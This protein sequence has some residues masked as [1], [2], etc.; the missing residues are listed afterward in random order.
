MNKAVFV[1]FLLFWGTIPEI[2]SKH[3]VGGEIFYTCQGIDVN[4][5][6][7]RLNFVMNIYRDCASTGADFDRPAKL[8]IYIK[9][10]SGSYRLYSVNDWNLANTSIVQ[11]NNPCVVQPP[12]ICVQKG[13]YV[14]SINLPIISES[15]FISYQ[16]CC[17]NESIS[18][19]ITP[20]DFGAAYT[21]EITPEAQRTC[22]NSPV[23][24]NFPPIIICNNQPIDFDH[25]VVDNEGDVVTYEFCTPYH[26][27]GKAGSV[28]NLGQ[29]TD[30]DGVTPDA[31][32]CIP[33]FGFIVFKAPLYSTSR[34]MGG[35]PI[36]SINSNTGFISGV[37]TFEGQYVV[38]VCIK[39]YRNGILLS[40]VQRD[41]QFNVINC[42]KNI[43]ASISSD[44]VLAG[45]K[46]IVNACG[47]N[48]VNLLN[49]STS[50]PIE[51]IRRYDWEFDINGQIQTF[52][53]KDISLTLPGNGSYK[54]FLYLNRG[55]GECSDTAEILINV[56]PGI[57]ADYV[58]NYDTCIAGPIQFTDLSTALNSNLV[59]WKYELEPG[60]SLLQRNPLYEYKT[61]GIKDI[62][63][64]IIDDNGC[65]DS[66]NKKINYYP[67]PALIVLNPNTFKGCQ[68]LDVYFENLS[69]PIDN[70]YDIEWDFGNG[71]KS[72]EISPKLTFTDEGIFTVNLKITSPIGCKTSAN[73][74]NWID[75]QKSPV[76]GFDFTPRKLNNFNNTID[77]TDLSVGSENHK[78]IFGDINSTPDRNLSYTFPDT[79][80][81][82]ISQI[83][84]RLNGCSDT[85]VQYIDVEPI[86]T[87]FMPNAFTPNGNGSNEVF[88][89]AGRFWEWME[90][91]NFTIWDRWGSKIY[92]SEDPNK[93]WNG[94]YDNSGL[95][96]QPGVYAYTIEY[97]AP[98]NKEVK[99]KGH[100]N[101]IR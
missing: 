51:N 71:I 5:N 20:G 87:Y 42:T 11:S 95:E 59:E 61:P 92:Q 85:L 52:K 33:P 4:K 23:F 90:N 81:H 76:A 101:L 40:V 84:S 94:R 100:V 96:V 30:C 83:V 3:I 64:R 6:Q 65:V 97:R 7:V 2:F 79:G 45:D 8:G 9:E 15:Y 38:G 46:Y 60:N 32:R 34:P 72:K 54:G 55:D 99:L 80:I 25:S 48:T 31:S 27:G 91:F 22:N 17:R 58:F 50:L 44:S 63:L 62:K 70:T 66:V 36:V 98:R 10:T 39:E 29:A 89:G 18:N 74:P 14:F 75:V 1:L 47:D 53:D 35:N 77:L 57:N 73:Y 67:V 78:Y 56:F 24:K 93:G 21:L 28:G 26:A 69:Y 19:I 37:P 16:R 13:V 43:N 82:K 41:F 12:S 68:P 86:L 88:F 49:T